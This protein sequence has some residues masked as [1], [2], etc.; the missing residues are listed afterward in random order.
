MNIIKPAIISEHFREYRSPIRTFGKK[1]RHGLP[2]H[3]FYHAAFA[4]KQWNGTETALVLHYGDC[5]FLPNA[6]CGEKNFESGAKQEGLSGF[7]KQ[8][9]IFFG[10][11]KNCRKHQR[12]EVLPLSPECPISACAGC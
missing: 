5:R 9:I 1:Q 8:D 3:R 2:V 11:I 12:S 7:R 4:P 6:N 10:L